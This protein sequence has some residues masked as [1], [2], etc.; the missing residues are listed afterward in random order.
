[1]PHA[2]EPADQHPRQRDEPPEKS[3][4]RARAEGGPYIGDRDAQ[5]SQLSGFGP[6]EERVK[7]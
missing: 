4:K 2:M 1:M 7:E 3:R 6:R 5:R